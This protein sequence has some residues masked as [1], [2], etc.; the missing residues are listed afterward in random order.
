MKIAKKKSDWAEQLAQLK[1]IPNF[2]AA[3]FEEISG[4]KPEELEAE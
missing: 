4:I 1:A 3:I 2:D